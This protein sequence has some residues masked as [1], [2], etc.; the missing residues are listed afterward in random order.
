MT[1]LAGFG[2]W[3]VARAPR[4]AARDAHQYDP[5]IH[6]AI[7]DALDATHR[8]RR[9]GRHLRDP[10]SIARR[11]GPECWTKVTS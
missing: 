9:C 11:I 4:R 1:A 7:L 3:L 10:E 6:R 8:C 5:E 2:E